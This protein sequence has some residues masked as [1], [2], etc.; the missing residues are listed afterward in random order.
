MKCLMYSAQDMEFKWP[1]IILHVLWH[2]LK[3][4]FGWFLS[5]TP[6]ITFNGLRNMSLITGQKRVSEPREDGCRKTRRHGHGFCPYRQ[7]PIMTN[8]SPWSTSHVMQSE[9]SFSSKNSTPSCPARSGMYSMIASRTRHFES[10]ASSTIA[11]N[12]DWD[13]WKHNAQHEV[14]NK[15][16][17]FTDIILIKCNYYTLFPWNRERGQNFAI[18]RSCI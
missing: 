15:N 10:S 18:K 17:L 13:S 9:F 5:I 6:V 11:G 16:T 3:Q 7:E 4:H 8:N 2:W 1:S 12:N 14:V